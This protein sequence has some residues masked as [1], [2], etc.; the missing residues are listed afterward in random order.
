[1]TQISILKVAL[2]Q[3]KQLKEVC[4]DNLLLL[5]SSSHVQISRESFDSVLPN[6]VWPIPNSTGGL[7]EKLI[8]TFEV[9]ISCFCENMEDLKD[10]ASGNGDGRLFLAMAKKLKEFDEKVDE[11]ATIGTG[12]K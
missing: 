9:L 11:L 5:S 1:M 12:S 4:A 7:V 2:F 3:L 6:K 10:W 8:S